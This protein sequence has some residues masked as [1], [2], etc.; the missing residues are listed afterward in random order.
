MK[1]IRKKSNPRTAIKKLEAVIKDVRSSV[2]HTKLVLSLEDLVL[3]VDLLTKANLAMRK[4]IKEGQYGGLK[5]GPKP[6]A[7]S[8]TGKEATTKAKGDES[9]NDSRA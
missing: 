4:T 9:T 8:K 6:R 2:P 7:L 3:D 5:D 1:P